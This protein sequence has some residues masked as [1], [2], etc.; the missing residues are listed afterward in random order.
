MRT[1]FVEKKFTVVERFRLN[2]ETEADARRMAK[3]GDFEPHESVKQPERI[4]LSYPLAKQEQASGHPE[5]HPEGRMCFDC[6]G[7]PG[8]CHMNCGPAVERAK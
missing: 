5:R 1:Y 8:S 4:T 3:S 2:A 7:L 6:D